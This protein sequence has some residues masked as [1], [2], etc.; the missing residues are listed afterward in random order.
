MQALIDVA[1]LAAFLVAYLSGGIYVA[2]AVLMLRCWRCC[3]ST[4]C[5]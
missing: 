5:G 4:G 3:W 2:T 1:P